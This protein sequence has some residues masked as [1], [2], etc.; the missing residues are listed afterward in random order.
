MTGY[1]M[2]SFDIQ[3]SAFFFTVL[4][5]L[6][7]VFVNG[8]T[9][10]PNAIA[11]AVATRA[12]S[13]KKAVLISAIF[14]FLGIIIMTII[15]RTVAL[16]VAGIADFGNSENASAALCGALASVIIWAVLAWAFGIPTSES[17]A[18]IAGL[19]GAAIS[20]GGGIDAINISEWIKVIYGL[21]V[22]LVPGCVIGF[23]VTKIII[24]LFEKSN[25][26]KTVVFFNKAQIAGSA[27]TS[28]MHGAQDGEKFIGVLL[29]GTMLAKGETAPKE[30]AIPGVLLV[31]CSI[32][33]STG[34]LVGGYRIIKTVGMDMAKLEGYQAFAADI[35]SS[36]C[37]FVSS[38]FGMPVSTTHTK[39]AAII[40]TGAA[41]NLRSVN[42]GVIGNMIFAWIMT[43]P[44][45]TIIGYIAA[46]VFMWLF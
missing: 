28:F 1:L 16:T 17:H 45:C 26:R 11:T 31:I 8:W 18:I 6:G 9:D 12:I 7:V 32:V 10:A 41:K 2:R 25:R 34:T 33:M 27:A 22:S 29:L 43:F 13:P 37:L 44:C 23:V 38:V 35:S 36:L 15:N 39:T 19:T 21:I 14:N 24:L 3:S 30:I 20:A 42:F 40:G 4:L 46:K 5:T